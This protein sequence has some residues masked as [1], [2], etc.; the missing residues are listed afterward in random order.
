M[1]PV[2]FL[3]DIPSFKMHLTLNVSILRDATS[4]YPPAAAGVN[5]GTIKDI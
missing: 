5:T 1:I 2:A 3:Q 4:F